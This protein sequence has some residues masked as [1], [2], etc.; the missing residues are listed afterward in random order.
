[1]AMLL[2]I[3]LFLSSILLFPISSATTFSPQPGICYG[4]L[5]DNLPPPRESVSLITSVHAKRVKLYDANPSILHALQDTRLQVSI[6]VPNDLILNISTNQTL[7]DQWVSDNVVP[8]HP[9]TLI[10]YLLVG[11]EVTSTTAATA[12]WPHLVPAMRRIKR[13]LKS[14]GIRKIK[15]GTSSAMDVLQTSFPPS[16][17]AFRKD[18]TAPVMKPMLKFLNRTKSFFFLDVY[19]FFT[20]SADPLNINLDYALFESKTVTV[21]DPVSGLVYTNLFDQMVDAVY[22]A[23]KRL[24]FPGVRIFIAETGW[25]N[26]G[27]LDQIGANTYNAATYNRNFIKKVTKK[28]RVGTPARPGS[29]LPSFLFALF[30]ENQKPGPSTERHFGLLHPNG[31]R[32]YDV[33]LSGETP[34]AE[35]RPL[36]VPENNEKFKGRIWCVAARRD[37]ATAL[38]A[39]LAY[40]CSQ[41]NGTCDPIQSKGKCFKPDSV[42]WHASYAFSAY[43]AQF[44]KVGGTCYFNGLATQ[45]AKDPSYGSCKFPSVTL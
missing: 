1:M 4:Q 27:D 26:G 10:R 23:M 15:V 13:S 37:N 21:K 2:L 9:R 24:G 8:Y 30:N 38:T 6:M 11:N 25:P 40:A 12:T 43:W 3:P 36:P 44:R 31:S 19:P 42:F 39:A 29:A 41:G 35:F 45:T 32:V 17:G 7:S 14:H 16:N 18:L 20:W 33:D 5:G 28:P 22:F 34:E